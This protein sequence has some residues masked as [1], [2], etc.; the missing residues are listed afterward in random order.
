M[1]FCK[2]NRSDMASYRIEIAEQ[3]FSDFCEGNFRRKNKWQDDYK[4]N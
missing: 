1:G 2:L 3:F 4:Q